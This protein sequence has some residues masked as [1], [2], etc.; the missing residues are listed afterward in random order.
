MKRFLGGVV[1]LVAASLVV[2]APAGPAGAA[3]LTYPTPFSYFPVCAT[4][5]QEFCI[6]KFEFT[7]TG[8][9]KQDLSATA[10]SN[11]FTNPFLEVFDSQPN[12]GPTGTPGQ[13]GKTNTSRNGLGN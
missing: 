7:P 9:A 3:A 6:E 10:S 1:A 8:G 12:T 4:A 2:S 11:Q 13:G 5:D